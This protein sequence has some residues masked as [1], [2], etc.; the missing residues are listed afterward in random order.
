MFPMRVDVKVTGA[1]IYALKMP[2]DTYPTS[3]L[4]LVTHFP[5]LG[6]LGVLS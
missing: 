5:E 1:P 4:Y 2:M 6:K 3:R